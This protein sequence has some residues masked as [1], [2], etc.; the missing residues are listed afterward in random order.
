MSLK[1]DA[2]DVAVRQRILWIGREAYPLHNISRTGTVK[3][4]PRV[5]FLIWNYIKFVLLWMLLGGAAAYAVST[6]AKSAALAT[7][8][9]AVVLVIIV[10]KTIR[11]ARLLGFTF[12]EL[13]I[14]TAGASRRALLSDNEQVVVDLVFRI[15]DAINN[16]HAEF[17][18]RVEN[19]HVGDNINQHG[20][21][22][23]A[24]VN[25]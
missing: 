2:I 24:K 6:Y 5:G 22:N 20:F 18:V 25:A 4:K 21:I 9:G 1:H 16:P 8:A 15:T 23:A 7:A 3:W 13:T 10:L 12:Y 11:V 19:F 17:Q 14:E